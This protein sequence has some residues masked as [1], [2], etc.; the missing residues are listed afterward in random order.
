M[1]AHNNLLVTIYQESCGTG[2]L[3]LNNFMC[4]WHSDIIL[5][6]CLRKESPAKYSGLCG[7]EKLFWYNFL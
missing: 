7:I 6:G 4:C 5:C 3:L 1:A 2:V